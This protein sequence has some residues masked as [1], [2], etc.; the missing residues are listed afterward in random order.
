M[1]YHPYLAT[2]KGERTSKKGK[3]IA[4]WF[5]VLQENLLNPPP[6]G[7]SG[8]WRFAFHFVVFGTEGLGVGLEE[9]EPAPQG[10]SI[11]SS[12]NPVAPK[13]IPEL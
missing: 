5:S 10:I 12:Y 8:W 9:P 2:E 11:C 1:I 7:H 3:G 4:E 13:G 6:C